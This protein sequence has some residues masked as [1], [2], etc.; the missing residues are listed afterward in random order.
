MRIRKL[1][2]DSFY[3]ND[4]AFSG[5]TSVDSLTT[6]L[7]F[8]YTD[9]NDSR[10]KLSGNTD[11]TASGIILED[12]DTTSITVTPSSFIDYSGGT[13][14]I[15]SIVNQDGVNV[16]SECTFSSLNTSI[17]TVNSTGLITL[18]HTGTT[19]IV[20]THADGP[21]GGTSVTG[22]WPGPVTLSPSVNN[23]PPD[24]VSGVTG[25][26]V[27]FTLTSD[28]TGVNITSLAAWTIS[29]TGVTIGASTGVATI[30]A[31]AASQ[32]ANVT[33]TYGT[34]AESGAYSP[35]T[36]FTIYGV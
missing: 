9:L 16:F 21:T 10:W 24:V 13:K 6:D 2:Y 36:T 30:A 1:M 31:G 12:S 20:T 26:T 18:I 19:T 23:T 11:A 29:A 15:S 17:A 5:V 3:V 25:T 35:S 32:T 14:Q 27:N 33:A 22:Y 8:H 4:Q 28:P 34:L 7:Y